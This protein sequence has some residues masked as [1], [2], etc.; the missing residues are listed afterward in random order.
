MSRLSQTRSRSPI[1]CIAGIW[2]RDV[3]VE[4]KPGL[5]GTAYA[6]KAAPD[7]YTVLLVSNGHAVI[8]SLNANLT[9]DP[10][11]SLQLF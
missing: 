2:K 5:A 3:I 10:Q 4:N 6:A 8:E 1:R 7:G 11:I 9:F